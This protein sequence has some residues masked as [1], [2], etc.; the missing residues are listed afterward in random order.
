MFENQDILQ[1]NAALPVHQP[2]LRR[3][4]LPIGRKEQNAKKDIK[5][6]LLNFDRAQAQLPAWS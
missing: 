4:N 6:F 3:K 5:C 1:K 2:V